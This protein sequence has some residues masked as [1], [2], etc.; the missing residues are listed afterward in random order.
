MAIMLFIGKLTNS[1]ESVDLGES[2]NSGDCGESED[3]CES[4]DSEEKKSAVYDETDDSVYSVESG[5]P[6]EY[7]K[8]CLE[9]CICSPFF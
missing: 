6:G 1:C 8:Y 7:E 3:C 9:M 4:C 2:F 5:D